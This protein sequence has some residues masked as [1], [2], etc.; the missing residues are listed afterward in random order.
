[1]IT[2]QVLPVII[3]PQFSTFEED[4]GQKAVGIK[5]AHSDRDF[6]TLPLVFFSKDMTAY[7]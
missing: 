2:R 6:K 1:V 7:A 5:I 4:L 3:S